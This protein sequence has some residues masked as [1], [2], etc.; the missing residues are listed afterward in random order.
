MA[1]IDTL[2]I[3]VYLSIPEVLICST[4]CSLTFP[5]CPAP[6]FDIVLFVSFKEFA[7]GS[8]IPWF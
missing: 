4:S 6:N 7:L 2:V 8:L 3:S 1:A 5:Y